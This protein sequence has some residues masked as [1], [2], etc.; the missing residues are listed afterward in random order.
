MLFV[1]VVSDSCGGLIGFTAACLVFRF[2]L[3]FFSRSDLSRVL[4]NDVSRLLRSRLN[5]ISLCV[6]SWHN[7]RHLV[8]FVVASVV[9]LGG[10]GDCQN[11]LVLGR[12]LTKIV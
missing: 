1:V 3:R 12:R 11:L 8:G 7:L 5:L 9:F 6:G 10:V 2:F 4:L